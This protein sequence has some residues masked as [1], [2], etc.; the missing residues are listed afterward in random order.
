MRAQKLLSTSPLAQYPRCISRPDERTIYHRKGRSQF[1]VV[2]PSGVTLPV[3]SERNDYGKI[4][5][6]RKRHDILTIHEHTCRTTYSAV[7]WSRLSPVGLTS[8]CTRSV[9]DAIILQFSLSNVG[10]TFGRVLHSPSATGALAATP[11]HVSTELA[12]I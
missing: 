4:R 9:I 3:V 7:A 1:M 2:V 8:D 6:S 11:T 12:A 5:P 10:S